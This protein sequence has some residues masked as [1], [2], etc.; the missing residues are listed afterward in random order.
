MVGRKCKIHIGDKFDRLTVIGISGR[1]SNNRILWLCHCICGNT[2]VTTGSN[3]R[4]GGTRSCGCLARELLIERNTTDGLFYHE[5]RASWGSMWDRCTNPNDPNWDSYGGRGIK[6]C[7]RWKDFK[8]FLEDV[9][10]RPS[11]KHSLDRW[12]DNDGDYKPDNIRWATHKEQNNNRRNNRYVTYNGFTLTV[13]EWAD[14]LQISYETL[15]YRLNHWSIVKS[16]TT[17]VKVR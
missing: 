2:K 1:N 11:K 17:P 9:G 13:A 6:V 16:L 15:A 12:P 8:L 14:K 5:L 3:L 10:D 7:E 4:S